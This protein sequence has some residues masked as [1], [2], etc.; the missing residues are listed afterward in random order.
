MRFP[1]AIVLTALGTASPCAAEDQRA[2]LMG[3]GATPCAGYSEAF[4]QSGMDAEAV[5]FSWA[6]GFMSALNLIRMERKEPLYDLSA[7][8]VPEQGARLRK[9]CADK[10]L[11]PYAYAVEDLMKT[12]PELPPR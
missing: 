3:A 8:S 7:V 4:R 2:A 12:F 5:F 9:L 6:Q 10:P 11:V 1:A